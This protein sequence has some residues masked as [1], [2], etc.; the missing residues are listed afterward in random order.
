[1]ELKT[2]K[3]V[4]VP[5]SA[6]CGKEFT[7]NKNMKQHVKEN[8]P[9]TK[10][11]HIRVP[12]SAGCGKEFTSNKNMNEHVKKSCKSKEHAALAMRAGAT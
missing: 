5:C 7:S 4:H 10:E 12:C 8:C 2:R 1:M 3:S 6:G 11:Q 9:K